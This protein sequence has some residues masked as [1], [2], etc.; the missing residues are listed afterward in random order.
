MRKRL[1]K[2]ASWF[3]ENHFTDEDELHVGVDVH[4]DQ[5][6]VAVYFDGRIGCVYSMSS[7]NTRLLHDLQ[8]VRCSLKNV[9][10]EAGPTG[11][12]LVR[13]L[14]SAGFPAEV[15]AATK[16]PRMVDS[17]GKTDRL[18]CQ[19]LA[20]YAAKGLLTYIAIPTEQQE[21]DR[22]VVRL[23][24]QLMSKRKRVM[25]QIKSFLLQYGIAWP[26]GG[27]SKDI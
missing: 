15:V 6:H 5:Y 27:W 4:K 10:Y 9:V 2:K 7:D 11:Y 21:S 22:Q 12:G 20:E 24:D 16:T 26:G 1:T 14:R 13:L 18:D 3:K 25:Q 19:Q 23:R 8:Q 17:A